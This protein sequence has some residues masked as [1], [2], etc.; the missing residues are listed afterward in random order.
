M[1]RRAIWG[2]LLWI[3]VCVFVAGPASAQ[4]CWTVA[5]STGTVD[6]ED[7]SRV[8]MANANLQVNS[9]APLPAVVGARYSVTGIAEDTG[10]PSRYWTVSLRYRDNGNGPDARVQVM[11][12]RQSFGTGAFTTLLNF[13]SNLYTQASGFQTINFASACVAGGGFS[14]FSNVYFVEATLTKSSA[15]GNPALQVIQ[16]CTWTC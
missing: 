12:Q 5:G 15:V 2:S 6:E 7:L 8:S 13:D 16:V 9:S 3:M 14:F 4:V 11:L 1:K 10:A